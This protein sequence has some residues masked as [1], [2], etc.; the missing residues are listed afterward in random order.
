MKDIKKRCHKCDT[1]LTVNTKAASVPGE[2]C[3]SCFEGS[4]T[5]VVLCGHCK[6]DLHGNDSVQYVDI[7]NS[8]PLCKSCYYKIMSSISMIGDK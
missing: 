5:K 4:N 6:K 8:I 3:R 1:P 7:M 2:L